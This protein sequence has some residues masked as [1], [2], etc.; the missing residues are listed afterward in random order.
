MTT[1]DDADDLSSDLPDYWKFKIPTTGG[2]RTST[3]T[4]A[5][6]EAHD[7]FRNSSHQFQ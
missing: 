5:S 3:T 6:S 7:L 4:T 1:P 2:S